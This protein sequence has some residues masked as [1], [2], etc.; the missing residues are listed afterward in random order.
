MSLDH[1]LDVPIPTISAEAS[2]KNRALSV[3]PCICTSLSAYPALFIST[4]PE[5]V[6]LAVGE[7]VPIPKFPVLILMATPFVPPVD[8]SPNCMLFPTVCTTPS[9]DAPDSLMWLFTLFT[10]SAAPGLAVPIPTF[11]IM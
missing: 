5:T 2:R 1:G 3:S 9:M 8:Q 7:E 4:P 6:S 11:P 10:S